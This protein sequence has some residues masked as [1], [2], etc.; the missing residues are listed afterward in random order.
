M[1][2]ESIKQTF[3]KY[4]F[5]ISSIG[6]TILYLLFDK[7]GRDLEKVKLDA[8]RTLL[9]QQ[10]ADIKSKSLRSDEDYEKARKAYIDLRARHADVLRKLGISSGDISERD[11]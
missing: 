5:I 7:R 4:W 8:Q 11:N 10:L 9:A 3:L 6:L 2:F 1:N